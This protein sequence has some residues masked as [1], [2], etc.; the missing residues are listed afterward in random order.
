MRLKT[1]INFT[2]KN[3]KI[4]FCSNKTPFLLEEYVIESRCVVK[5]QYRCFEV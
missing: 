5:Y 1:R 2:V 3:L 4:V